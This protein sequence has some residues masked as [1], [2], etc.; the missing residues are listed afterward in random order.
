MCVIVGF[1]RCSC[2]WNFAPIFSVHLSI[3][4]CFSL[5][6]SPFSF[7]IMLL[8]VWLAVFCISFGSSMPVYNSP[9]PQIFVFVPLLFLASWSPLSVELLLS[10]VAIFCVFWFSIFLLVLAIV[11]FHFSASFLHACDVYRYRF[12]RKAL[13]FPIPEFESIRVFLYCVPVS[14]FWRYFPV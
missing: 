13:Y 1:S 7:L 9:Y 8:C 14:V 3:L 6:S 10:Y 2:I 11:Y 12:L 5:V 4:P